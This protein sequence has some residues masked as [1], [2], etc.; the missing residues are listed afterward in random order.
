VGKRTVREIR[1][2]LE[3]LPKGINQLE[4][5]YS[6]TIARIRSQDVND[7][8]RARKVFCWVTHVERPLSIVE[9][10]QALAVKA[11]DT[12]LDHDDIVREDEIVAICSGLITVDR[13]GRIV[14][15]IHYT[16]AEYLKGAGADW[17]A[18][19]SEVLA[20]TCLR[21]YLSSPS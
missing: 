3:G 15:L 8:C 1:C 6:Q 13:Y 16:T 17:I 18:D 11:D 9:L 12:D 14:R 4:Q 2:A 21:F 20:S 10:Q 19:A 5:A 7:V